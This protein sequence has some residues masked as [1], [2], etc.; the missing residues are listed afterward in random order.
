MRKFVI[1]GK[2]S[3]AVMLYDTEFGGMAVAT[4]YTVRQLLSMGAT[5]IGLKSNTTQFSCYI[6]DKNENRAL[7]N[8]VPVVGTKRSATTFIKGIKPTPAEQKAKRDAENAEKEKIR[9]EKK[10]L[11]EKK[12]AEKAAK[13]KHRKRAKELKEEY[14][15]QKEQEKLLKKTEVSFYNSK[16]L[17]VLTHIENIASEYHEQEKRYYTLYA[18]TKSAISNMIKV[19]QNYGAFPAYKLGYI[20]EEIRKEFNRNNRVAC[21]V[22]LIEMDNGNYFQCVVGNTVTMEATNH[23]EDCTDEWKFRKTN[24]YLPE[25]TGGRHSD[26]SNT[27]YGMTAG[28]NEIS[29]ITKYLLGS[30]KLRNMP[31]IPP[32]VYKENW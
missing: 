28:S 3:G 8:G 24:G 29:N 12:K 2:T 22:S 31:Y 1:V 16:C 21:N 11:Q 23:Y 18:E 13:A 9:A 32:C 10:A 5:I 19:L 4:Y 14:K 7:G 27:S 25:H 6:M 20:I 30:K 17:C 15:K 26:C